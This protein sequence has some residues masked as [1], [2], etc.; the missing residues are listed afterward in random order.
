MNTFVMVFTNDFVR[1]ERRR[2]G[3]WQKGKMVEGIKTEKKVKKL[4]SYKNLFV[5]AVIGI[6]GKSADDV[7]ELLMEADVEVREHC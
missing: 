5:T 6:E 7:L 2:R 1:F 4:S 3:R